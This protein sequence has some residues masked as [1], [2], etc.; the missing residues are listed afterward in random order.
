MSYV[1]LHLHLLP[2]VDDGPRDEREALEHAARMVREGVTEAV[3]TPHVGHPDFPLEVA[4]IA[5]RTRALRVALDRELIGLRIRPGGEIHPAGL[6]TMGPGELGAVAHGPPGARWVLAEVPFGGIDDAFLAGCRAVR[7]NGFGLV[8]AHPER[9]AGWAEEGR[10][11]LEGELVAG[12]VLQV[13]VCSLLGHH[14]P[15]VRAS[16]Q[17]LV[18]EG[19]AYVLASDGHG[20]RR[21]QTLRLGFDLAVAA[22]ASSVQAWRLTQANPR[23]LLRHGLPALP[24]EVA[25]PRRS[26][27]LAA[28]RAARRRLSAAG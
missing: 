2:G 5:A 6:A 25:A 15:D 7:A 28:V 16:A 23:F 18:R 22:G 17:R 14:G 8:I 11:R 3:V 10:A 12:A 9:A 24:R 27:G 20:A 4:S 13:N 19:A 21:P 1:D 26:V